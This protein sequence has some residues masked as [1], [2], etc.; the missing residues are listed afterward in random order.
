MRW[1][2]VVAAILAAGLLA[3]LCFAIVARETS[4]SADRPTHI[5]PPADAPMAN[6]FSG[7]S[8]SAVGQGRPPPPLPARVTEH[9]ATQYANSAV[10][11]EALTQIAQ[12]WRQAIHEVHTPADA[13]EAGNA[14]A[15]GIACALS[16]GVLAKS[17]V[18]QQAMLDRIKNT[19]AVMLDTEADTQAYIRFQSLAGGQYF[20]DPGARPCRFDPSLRQN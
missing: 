1:K 12:G 19:R 8:S 3:C 10:T 20:N 14:I 6:A 16:Q 17:G 11:R 2:Y 4:A 15:E 7:V 13:K 18:D 5:D 9:I